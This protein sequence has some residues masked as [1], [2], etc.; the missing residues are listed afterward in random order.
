MKLFEKAG[1]K[2]R[3]AEVADEKQTIVN[4]V[5]ARLGAGILPRWTSRMAVP[6]V[7]FVRLTLPGKTAGDL[8]LAAA[9]LRGSRDPTREAILEVLM[10]RLKHYAMSA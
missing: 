5:A 1:L 3:T 7:R 9:W 6:G 4:L 2:P 8:P 10:S